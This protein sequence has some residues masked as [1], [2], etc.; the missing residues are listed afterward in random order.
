[1][2]KKNLFQYLQLIAIG[3]ISWLFLGHATLFLYFIPNM[4]PRFIVILSFLSIGLWYHIVIPLVAFA[5]LTAV[6]S[7][8]KASYLTLKFFLANCLISLLQFITVS[9]C[10]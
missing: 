3:T 4:V 5:V 7:G 8:L 9:Q 10:I 2:E 1:M 6:I